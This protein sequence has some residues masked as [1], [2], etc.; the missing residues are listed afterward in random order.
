M[1]VGGSIMWV[2]LVISIIALAFVIER[3]VFFALST[4]DPGR[5]E[6]DFARAV[7]DNDMEKAR[8][9]TSGRSSMH[10][11]FSAAAANW[12]LNND[13]IETLLEQELRRELF[14]WE[15]N[16]Y[17]LEITAKVSPLL[18][19]LGTV[20]GMAE[21]FRTLN[22]G[23]A[24]NS[25]A[26]TGGIWKALFTTVAGLTVAIPIIIAHG[27]LAGRIGREEETLR[28]GMDAITRLRINRESLRE[29]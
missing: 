5:I 27:L 14:R 1:Q 16:L 26:V 3:V 15:K 24:V 28:R 4:A 17:F 13:G 22:L 23:G 21:M 18:G 6:V 25:T 12:N 11:L 7:A 9:L 2:I 10:R 19:L 29:K 20:L 8:S